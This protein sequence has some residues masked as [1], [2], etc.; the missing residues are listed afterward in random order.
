MNPGLAGFGQFL[1]IFAK[2][3]APAQPGQ[4]ALHYP[5]AGQYLEVVAVGTAAHHLQQPAAGRPSPRDQ[6]TGISGVSPDDLEPGG[7]GSAAWP[8]PTWLRPGPGYWPHAPPLRGAIPWCPLRCGACVPTP[9]CLR[10]SL[11]APF[12]RGF[13]R[14]AVDDGPAGGGIPSLALPDHGAQCLLHPLPSAVFAPFPEIPPDCAPRRQVMG[15]HSPG[16]AAAQNVQ[17]AVNHHP[18]V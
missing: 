9:F 16:Y 18:Q 3:S 8:A 11:E 5:P 10:H 4:C 14:L 13:Y 2:P 12:F 6:L 1:V 17:Y 15:H 7:N